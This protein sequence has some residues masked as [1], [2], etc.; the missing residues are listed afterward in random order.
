M[1]T[2]QIIGIFQRITNNDGVHVYEN[3]DIRTGRIEPKLV[4]HGQTFVQAEKIVGLSGL[5]RLFD[6]A[7]NPG[8]S[9]TPASI[10]Q[11]ENGRERYVALYFP[12]VLEVM[13]KSLIVPMLE[14]LR[15]RSELN[16]L[17]NLPAF[18]NGQSGVIDLRKLVRDTDEIIANDNIRTINML[19]DGTHR[20][21]TM[22]IAGTTMH[23]IMI[24]GAI[25]IPTG[26]PILPNEMVVT[27]SKPARM[28]DRYLGF[29]QSSWMNYKDLGID[30]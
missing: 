30:G 17:L 5:K 3:T 4:Y 28:E 15:K 11:Y 6:H 1:P 19:R 26:V 23:A 2:D 16:P 27:S 24:N 8:I 29:D 10:I 14:N 25:A 13:E 12:V 22:N 7:D 18:E 20:S 9:K 21:H